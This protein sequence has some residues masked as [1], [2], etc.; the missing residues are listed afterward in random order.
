[1][2]QDTSSTSLKFFLL[3]SFPF[4][5]LFFSFLLIL[6]ILLFFS[7]Y[8]TGFSKTAIIY[9]KISLIS[10]SISTPNYLFIDLYFT[11]RATKNCNK[12]LFLYLFLTLKFQILS[13][14][15]LI[16][17]TILRDGIFFIFFV[18]FSS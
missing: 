4:S 9:P 7:S 8:R 11:D 13:R 18:K 1:M 14:V 2:Y 16:A 6:L 3:Y 15:K 12:F 10:P 5:F 17:S